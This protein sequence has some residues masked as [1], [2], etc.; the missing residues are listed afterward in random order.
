MEC[1]PKIKEELNWVEYPEDE[2]LALL[3][4]A[5]GNITRIRILKLLIEKDSCVCNEIV[6]GLPIS[7]STVS[8][9]LKVLKESG[10]IKGTIK[11][12]N[13]CYCVNTDILKK[14]KLLI[15]AL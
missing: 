2:E 15:V 14:L 5:L 10:L 3:T 12:Y 13:T 6:E 8:Q 9:H 1:K 4:K 11:G 7:Q